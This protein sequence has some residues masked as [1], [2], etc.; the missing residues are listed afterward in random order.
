MTE[1]ERLCRELAPY[2]YAHRAGA[3]LEAHGLKATTLDE[4]PGAARA[5]IERRIADAAE[6][7]A[8]RALYAGP[9]PTEDVPGHYLVGGRDAMGF[10]AAVLDRDRELEGGALAFMRGNALKYLIR[11]PRKGGAEDYLKAEDYCMRLALATEA[12]RDAR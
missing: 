8:A 12:R 10:I 4:D 5:D 9:E 11:A 6:Q 3:W 1:L 2:V 7:D